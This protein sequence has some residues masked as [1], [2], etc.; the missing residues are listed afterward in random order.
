MSSV[1]WDDL[2]E[3]IDDPDALREYVIES[4]RISTVDRLV[5]DLSE[6]M[7]AQD[8]TRAEVARR[9]NTQAAT[10]RRLLTQ[11]GHNPTVGTV[12]EV[13]GVLGY[14]LEL[15]AMSDQERH[16]FTDPLRMAGERLDRGA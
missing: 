13:A 4:L 6:A 2:Q 3:H 10:I 14:R 8:V 11:S 7:D 1:F 15:V 9:L 16:R 12:A 5:N